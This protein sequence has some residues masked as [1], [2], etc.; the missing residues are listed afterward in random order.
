[1]VEHVFRA[2]VTT[3]QTDVS[4][5][6]NVLDASLTRQDSLVSIASMDTMEMHSTSSVMVSRQYIERGIS[7]ETVLC[8]VC[9]RVKHE[10][11][12]ESV[13]SKEI[14][15]LSLQASDSVVCFVLFVCLFLFLFFDRPVE[16]LV[17]CLNGNLRKG[18]CSISSVV[19]I[20][21]PLPPQL[22]HAVKL[23]PW[24]NN[25]IGSVVNAIVKQK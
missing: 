1:M 2:N 3:T 8:C 11:I 25:V 19:F 16:M 24:I 21:V 9:G 23:V 7:K 5:Q 20:F 18:I 10:L 15:K 22:V 6:E 4:G 13:H 14:Q 12:G 17:K